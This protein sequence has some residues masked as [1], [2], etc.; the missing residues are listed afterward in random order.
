[1]KSFISKNWKRILIIIGII[2]IAWNGIFKIIAKKALLED[3]VKYGKV[4]EKSVI[5]GKIADSIDKPTSLVSPEM[6]KL[7]IIF[8]VA[9]LL[10]VFISS[11]GS[12]SADKGKKK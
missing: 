7:T 3:Y 9:I 2:C 12:K 8:M 10:V 5:I 11:L 4:G 1:M 6:V